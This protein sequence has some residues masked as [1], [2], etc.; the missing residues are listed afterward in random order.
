MGQGESK[1]RSALELFIK[2]LE[3]NDEQSMKE[4]V[5]TEELN[6]GTMLNAAIR[7]GNID[8]LKFLVETCSIMLIQ[9]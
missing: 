9:F 2:A 5:N 1:E 3:D 8:R 6:D 7:R 4:I